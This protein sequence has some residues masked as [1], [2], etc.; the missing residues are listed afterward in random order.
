MQKLSTPLLPYKAS[1][2]LPL[3]PSRQQCID[4]LSELLLAVGAN[5]DFLSELQE[6]L[7]SDEVTDRVFSRD[8]IYAISIARLL[9]GYLGTHPDSIITEYN[10]LLMVDLQ[11]LIEQWRDVKRFGLHLPS[12]IVNY[13]T[14]RY[15]KPTSRIVKSYSTMAVLDLVGLSREEADSKGFSK[16]VIIFI[17]NTLTLSTVEN[18]YKYLLN[19]GY[20]KKDISDMPFILA[21][22]ARQINTLLKDDERASIVH[23]GETLD[24]VGK[25][26]WIVNTL[27]EDYGS[28]LLKFIN[29]KAKYRKTEESQL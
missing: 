27:S 10:C 23:S 25:L 21:F 13:L 11:L 6:K 29:R 14:G 3:K 22:S 1:V 7:Y 24:N 18:T 19:V 12:E 9:I 15:I 4:V 8:C 28:T 5:N 26:W 20:T 17:L 2:T 16:E